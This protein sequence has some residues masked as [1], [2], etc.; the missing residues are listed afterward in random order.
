MSDYPRA[1]QEGKKMSRNHLITGPTD[2][3]DSDQAF[4]TSAIEHALEHLTQ[5]TRVIKDTQTSG[6]KIYT[7]KG[8][9]PEVQMA[10]Q[11]CGERSSK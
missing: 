10:L 5:A 8:E 7:L 9:T 11:R 1:D 4:V 6:G 3:S 2:Q